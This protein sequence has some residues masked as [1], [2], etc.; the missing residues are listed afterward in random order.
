MDTKNADGSGNRQIILIIE[1][2]PNTAALVALYLEREG[3]RPIA[4]GDG[5]QGIALAGRHHPDL[6]ILDLM[7]PK[8]DGWEVIGLA[9]VKELVEAHG[10]TVGAEKTDHT[11]RIWFALPLDPSRQP[12]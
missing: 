11:L 12:R 9:I 7:L 4:A 2:D 1:D 8:M 6:I 3:F 5:E 10:G